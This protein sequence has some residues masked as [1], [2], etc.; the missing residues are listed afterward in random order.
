MSARPP[1]SP[2][3]LGADAVAAVLDS[4]QAG[5]YTQVYM[6]VILPETQKLQRPH[7]RKTAVVSL[8]KA[9]TDST[10]FAEKYAKGWGYTCEALLKLMINPPVP[11]KDD[12]VDVADQ[13]ADDMEF[14]VGFT[15]L[16][17]VKKGVRDS[18]PET[19]ADLKAWLGEWLRRR[20]QETGGRIAGFVGSRLSEETRGVLVSYMQG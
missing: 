4:I 5:V 18:F 7:E 15:A 6:S 2:Q 11:S 1:P 14:G 13:D 17:T 19:G 12:G 10:A 8:A 16:G 20:D 3:N 9:L